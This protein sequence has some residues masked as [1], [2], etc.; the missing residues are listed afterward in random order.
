M[1]ILK[2]ISLNRYFFNIVMLSV[3]KF[4]DFN[5]VGLS[6]V[7]VFVEEWNVLGI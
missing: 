7:L 2:L 5:V 6:L 1:W 4:C 3:V